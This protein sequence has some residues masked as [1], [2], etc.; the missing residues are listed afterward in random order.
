M[1][2]FPQAVSAFA[3]YL[4]LERGFSSHSIDAYIRDVT[5]CTE[6]MQTE[7]SVTSPEFVTTQHLSE[8]LGN[9]RTLGLRASSLARTISAIRH[10]HLFLLNEGM[11][12]S[13]PATHIDNPAVARH[14][15]TVLTQDEMQRV[16]EQ[17]DTSSPLGIRDR[18]ILETLYATGMR[19]SE[20]ITLDT[21][22]LF[23]DDALVRIIGKGNKERIIPIGRIAILWLRRYLVEA[24]SRLVKHSNTNTSVFLNHRGSPL[25]RMSILNFVKKYSA[26]AGIIHDVHPH[27]FRHSF[28]THLLE[29]GADL[30][31]VQEMLGHSDI[32]T[33]QVYTHLDREYLK[34]VHTTFHPRA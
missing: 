21:R 27:T 15:P 2:S 28:A 29:G 11:C 24:R 32:S 26:M 14:L 6:W 18:A 1:A 9:L 4:N 25:S 7:R 17:P 34:E 19:V 23:L 8:F 13:N 3:T 16:L 22:Q 30:R 20:L 12:E 10:F 33:T 5:R 31:S